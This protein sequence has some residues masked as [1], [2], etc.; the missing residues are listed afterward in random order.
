MNFFS[1]NHTLRSFFDQVRQK[2]DQIT[3]SFKV[4]HPSHFLSLWETA[5][6]LLTATVLVISLLTATTDVLTTP[7]ENK[8]KIMI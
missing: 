6:I 4:T 3:K 1:K 5:Y 7:K 2:E 8:Q